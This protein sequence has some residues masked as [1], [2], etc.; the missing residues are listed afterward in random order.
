MP[1]S[2]RKVKLLAI[3]LKDPLSLAC[4]QLA[5]GIGCGIPEHKVGL[6]VSPTVNI[7]KR[8]RG[9]DTPR[10]LR[11]TALDECI[12]DEGAP[13]TEQRSLSMELQA[14]V[15]ICSTG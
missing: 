4:L 8:S 15:T 3:Q 7:L 11:M 1:L 14:E 10:G 6:S 13:L 5:I 2:R 9:Q 12:P